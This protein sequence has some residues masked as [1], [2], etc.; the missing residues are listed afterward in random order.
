MS[1]PSA[2]PMF[3]TVGELGEELQA[4]RG[5][6]ELARGGRH[7][8][9]LIVR[10]VRG[11]HGAGDPPEHL[12]RA[13]HD[14]TLR[15]LQQIAALQHEQRRGGQAAGAGS[16][17]LGRPADARS[18]SRSQAVYPGQPAHEPEGAILNIIDGGIPCGPVGEDS[19]DSLN[20]R[21]R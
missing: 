19:D 8:S 9:T 18:S 14:V 5:S 15:D 20:D 3:I 13:L 21:T 7:V 2:V 17:V 10:G 16:P 4:C 11:G 12:R 1:C 6:I